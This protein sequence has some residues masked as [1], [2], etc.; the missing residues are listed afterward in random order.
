VAWATTAR[1]S[2]T[3]R[4][5]QRRRRCALEDEASEIKAV[6]TA[7]GWMA[8]EEP[9][10]PN[11]PRPSPIPGGNQLRDINGPATVKQTADAL[12]IERTM[13]DA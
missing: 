10:R 2:T 4:G 6:L 1:T 3:F 7:V 11:Q 13:G 9:P 12:T 5:V 8:S